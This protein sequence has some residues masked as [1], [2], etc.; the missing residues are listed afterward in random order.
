MA[1]GVASSMVFLLF[2]SQGVLTRPVRT[3]I[4]LSAVVVLGFP[5]ARRAYLPGTNLFSLVHRGPWV[6]LERCAHLPGTLGIPVA[7][8]FVY[9]QPLPNHQLP[10]VTLASGSGVLPTNVGGLTLH[11]TCTRW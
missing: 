2:L 5:L 3:W 8:D 11:R 4:F 9:V 6:S 10:D 7:Q 1:E